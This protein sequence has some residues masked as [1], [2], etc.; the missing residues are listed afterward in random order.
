[1][2]FMCPWIQGSREKSLGSTSKGP[3]VASI[4]TT[5]KMDVEQAGHRRHARASHGGRSISAMGGLSCPVSRVGGWDN[6]TSLGRAHDRA[7]AERRRLSGAGGEGTPLASEIGAFLLPLPMPR[8]C[9]RRA[10]GRLSLE[11]SI[12]RWNRGRHCRAGALADLSRSAA[13]LG[14]FSSPCSA[15]TR[16]MDPGLGAQL[17]AGWVTDDL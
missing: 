3:R 4:G 16:R 13:S 9:D 8:L 1:M 12:Y 14:N 15:S 6:K 5:H 17:L 7:L 11:W 10:G 2:S